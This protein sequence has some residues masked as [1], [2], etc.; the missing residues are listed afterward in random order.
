[1]SY[2]VSEAFN[3]LSRDTRLVNRKKL[4]EDISEIKKEGNVSGYNIVFQI[5]PLYGCTGIPDAAYEF[6]SRVKPGHRVD[7]HDCKL[8]MQD[9]QIFAD[10]PLDS[11][12][13]QVNINSGYHTTNVDLH[14]KFKQESQEKLD[15]LISI[16]QDSNWEIID[17]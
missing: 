5:R 7:F 8:S 17:E 1:M 12:L 13:L 4:N 9:G 3:E 14:N 16:L 11:L 2:I 15:T 6:I 10:Y